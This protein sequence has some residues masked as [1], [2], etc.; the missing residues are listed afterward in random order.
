M[1][2]RIVVINPNS[3]EAVTAGI[4]QALDPLRFTGGPEIVCR[5]LKEGPPG[6]QSQRDVENV[7]QPLLALIGREHN[8]AAAFV[9]ACFSDPGLHVARE[10][11]ER[12]VFGIS[13]SGLASAMSLG[14][15]IG[16]IAI[17]AAS[18]PRHRRYFRSMGIESRICGERPIGLPVVELSDEA[19]T[20]GR[21]VTVGREL[22]DE[23]GAEVIVM[24]CAGMARYRQRL[25]DEL[26]LPVI[27]PSQAAVGQAI[28]AVR[29]GWR[30]RRRA[31]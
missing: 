1:T 4:D 14:D 29:L 18:M 20:Y 27:D 13:E 10:A 2:E 25:E 11:S 17:L 19:K 7:V 28:S 15:R 9:I 26:G 22:R 3:T 31:A 23:D 5:T 16:V 21:M 24:G 30:T 12:P 8:Q 6:I